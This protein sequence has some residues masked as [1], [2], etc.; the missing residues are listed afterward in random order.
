MQT[1]LIEFQIWAVRSIV[2][3]Y[4]PSTRLKQALS[5]FEDKSEGSKVLVD[6][7]ESLTTVMHVSFDDFDLIGDLECFICTEC[8]LPAVLRGNF[9][10][11]LSSF[12]KLFFRRYGHVVDLP[13]V[14]VVLMVP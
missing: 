10:S 6:Q 11:L 2:V 14:T 1:I 8:K 12:D 5:V 3:L 9:R 13:Y 4:M 7:S